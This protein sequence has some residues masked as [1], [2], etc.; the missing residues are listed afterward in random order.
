MVHAQTTRNTF[1]QSNFNQAPL[2]G[3]TRQSGM[4]AQP[5][6]NNGNNLG[7]SQNEPP[8]GAGLLAPPVNAG[9]PSPDFPQQTRFQDISNSQQQQQ[10]NNNQPMQA[11]GN[12]GPFR[13]Q[14]PAGQYYSVY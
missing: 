5:G 8:R 3:P 14:Q 10:Q 1:Q 12:G 11:G 7:P 2:S 13:P 6:N 9:R 4:G